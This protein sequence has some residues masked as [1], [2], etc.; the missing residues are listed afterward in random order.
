MTISLNYSQ[1]SLNSRRSSGRKT[2]LKSSQ[3]LSL[4]RS[5]RSYQ[6]EPF[7]FSARCQTTRLTQYQTDPASYAVEVLKVIWWQKQ[8]EIAQALL[9]P[10]HRV[11]V[12][13]CHKVGKTHLAGG[14]VNWWYDCFDPGLALTTAPTERQVKDLLWK[15]VRVQ[16]RGRPGLLPKAPRLESA[17]IHFLGNSRVD[18]ERWERVVGDF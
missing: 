12:K 16:R 15:E 11:L 17:P 8:I 3:P 10:P 4:P 2:G 13:A 14:L 9:T 18:D 1:L 5:M 7:N 6:T